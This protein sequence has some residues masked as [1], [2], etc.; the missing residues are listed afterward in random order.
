[1][2]TK[3]FISGM[4]LFAASQ[5]HAQ[6][7]LG[8]STTQ[9]TTVGVDTGVLD[10]PNVHVGYQAGK[11]SSNTPNPTGI[12]LGIPSNN[13]FVGYQS[14]TANYNGSNNTFLGFQSGVAN[15]NADK[16]V[17]LGAISGYSNT[18]GEYNVFTGYAAGSSNVTGNN[19]TFTGYQAGYNS[20]L[21]WL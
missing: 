11:M 17:F 15:Y 18:N 2:T 14:G 7:P 21:L 13:T 19:N 12:V 4:L 20:K 10:G 6:Y 5:V 1:M 3:L 8:S 9:R 16:N